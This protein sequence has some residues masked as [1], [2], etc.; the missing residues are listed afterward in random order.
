MLNLN[1]HNVTLVGAS[2]GASVVWSYFELYGHDR[3]AQAVFVDQAPLQNIAA[4]WKSGSTGCYDI[5]SLTRL[6]CRLIA[7]FPGFAKDNSDFCLS[8]PIADE[9]KKVLEM[10]TMR[11]NPHA[12]AA[13][14]ADHTAL[15]WR[16]L[17]PRINIP[18]LNIV[19]RHSQ[20]FPWWGCEATG[21]LI[22]N[23]RTVFFENCNHWLYIEEPGKFNTIITAFASGGIAGV[24][25]LLGGPAPT[26]S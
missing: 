9:V 26:L 8:A 16:P 17:L 14:M 19:G 23:C 20:V 4:D 22:P 6:Q 13:L 3:I 21:N 25:K 5:A 7:D 24:T 15:D 10:E 2:M 18:C 1:L 12:L 11:A